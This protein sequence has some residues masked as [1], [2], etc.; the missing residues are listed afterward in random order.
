MKEA[1]FRDQITL[2]FE[3]KLEPVNLKM[4]S[5]NSQGLFSLALENT[6][7]LGKQ[8]FIQF[9]PALPVKQ[10]NYRETSNVS[11]SSCSLLL[12]LAYFLPCQTG[13]KITFSAIKANSSFSLKS[14]D[15]QH[16]TQLII[17]IKPTFCH[18]FIIKP[19]CL[20]KFH[21]LGKTDYY[22]NNL[23]TFKVLELISFASKVKHSM[24]NVQ[25]L[26]YNAINL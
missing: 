9:I 23:S 3:S 17:L 12:K 19:K 18:F 5:F 20:E 4:G 6:L 21:E 10:I 11:L 15:P 25:F 1:N 14:F 13:L 26:R 24:Q 7:R 2:P 22:L 8:W 16:S